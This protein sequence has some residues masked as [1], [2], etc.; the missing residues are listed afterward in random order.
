MVDGLDA[1]PHDLRRVGAHIHHERNDGRCFGREFEAHARQAEIDDEN[2]H[3][4]GRVADQLDIEADQQPQHAPAVNPGDRAQRANNEAEGDR[5]YGEL[6]RKPGAVEEGR[7]FL[8]Q[9]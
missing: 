8:Q 1:R 7:P 4:Q 2:L 9:E 5:Q 3:E 6:N